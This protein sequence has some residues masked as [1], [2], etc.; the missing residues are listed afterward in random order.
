MAH[1]HRSGVRRSSSQP[2]RRSRL[3]FFDRLSWLLA[4]GL[5]LGIA[6]QIQTLEPPPQLQLHRDLSDWQIGQPLDGA[7]SINP[8]TLPELRAYALA[9]VN[10]DRTLNGLLPLVEDPLLN[11]AAQRHAEDMLNRQFFAHVNPDGVNPSGRFRAVGGQM[12]AGENIYR[13]TGGTTALSYSLAEK[14]QTGW[15]ESD[16]H[17]ANLLSLGYQAF[18]YGIAASPEGDAVYVVQMFR[19]PT[20]VELLQGAS[21]W[22]LDQLPLERFSR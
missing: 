19:P 7:N 11:L 9:L 3:R 10:R 21:Q 14:A 13:R 5:L 12:G 22:V 18:G 15:M 8:R 1:P 17:R 6:P 16:G 4:F 2:H 20:P